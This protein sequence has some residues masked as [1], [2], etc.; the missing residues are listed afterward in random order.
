ML[1]GDKLLLSLKVREAE[2]ESLLLVRMADV[3][4]GDQTETSRRFSPNYS[5]TVI[6]SVLAIT[7]VCLPP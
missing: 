6:Y 7:K 4:V 1:L 5:L 2:L 3:E